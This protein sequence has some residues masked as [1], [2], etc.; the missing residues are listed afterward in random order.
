MKRD[1]HGNIFTEAC[2][3]DKD[4]RPY[5]RYEFSRPPEGD[6]PI[7]R[8]RSNVMGKLMYNTGTTHSDPYIAEVAG[9][10][11]NGYDPYFIFVGYTKDENFVYD[12]DP[13]SENVMAARGDFKVTVPYLC[14]PNDNFYV[15]GLTV[16][17]RSWPTQ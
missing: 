17:E 4:S 2:S 8:I 16:G 11:I 15:T 7:W 5:W 9:N 14:H 6:P 3:F 13:H 1:F 12:S 10:N